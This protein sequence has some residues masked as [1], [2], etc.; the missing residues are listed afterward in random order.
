MGGQCPS[1][2]TVYCNGASSCTSYTGNA[3]CYKYYSTPAT[4]V[5]AASQCASEGSRIFLPINAN[6]QSLASTTIGGGHTDIS[7]G[8]QLNSGDWVE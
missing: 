6:Y 8:T 2:Y 3:I 7:I 1:G 5:N 4:I